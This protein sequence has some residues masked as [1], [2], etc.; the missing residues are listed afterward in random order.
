LEHRVN[1]NLP[2]H[3]AFTQLRVKY[4]K[5]EAFSLFH[6][7]FMH[8]GVCREKHSRPMPDR[9]EG[10]GMNLKQLE[11]IRTGKGFIAAMDQSGGSTPKALEHYGIQNSAYSSE[12]EMFDLVHQMRSRVIT[13]SAFTSQYIL[14]AILFEQTMERSVEGLPTA[15][16]LWNRKGIVPFLKIDQ[17]L[18]PLTDGVQLMKPIDGLDSLLKKAAEHHVFGTKMRSVIKQANP[19]GIRRV[20]A[21][22]FEFAARVAQAG[23]LPIIEPEVDIYCVNKFEA[24]ALLKQDLK[25]HLA[26][27]PENRLC[28]LKITIPTQDDFYADFEADKHVV[29]VVALSGGYARDEADDRL[30]RNHGLIAS[31]SRALME[32]LSASQSDE[33]FNATLGESI[34]KIYIASVKD[35]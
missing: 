25:K 1:C 2:E 7:R 8:R 24:E 29:R 23:L 9:K 15:D 20:I 19:A 31:F 21:Q 10:F 14:G 28:M 34:R 30:A 17:G 6:N 16:Y 13:S 5:S 4:E 26:Q 22:Q 12:K 3:C 33:A 35:D 27:L 11:R 18:S 32:G